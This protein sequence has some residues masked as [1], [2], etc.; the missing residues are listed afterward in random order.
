MYPATVG[1]KKL[2]SCIVTVTLISDVTN[3]VAGGASVVFIQ[4]PMLHIPQSIVDGDMFPLLYRFSSTM[5]EVEGSRSSIPQLIYTLSIDAVA[6]GCILFCL[7]IEM[8]TS[9]LIIEDERTDLVK[10]I[11]QLIQKAVTCDAKTFTSLYGQQLHSYSSHKI[12]FFGYMVVPR[13]LYASIMFWIRHY[14]LNLV[15]DFILNHSWPWVPCHLD[16][17]THQAPQKVARTAKKNVRSNGTIFY[18]G[19]W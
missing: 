18:R 3:T 16:A 7:D 15:L 10:V 9:G 6:V 19:D 17:H 1:D 4:L 8:E 14:S 11:F 12:M 2:M 13:V 5:L